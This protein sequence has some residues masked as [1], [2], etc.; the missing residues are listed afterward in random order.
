MQSSGRQWNAMGCNAKQRKAKQKQC[1][2]NAK[3]MQK[4]CDAKGNAQQ[5]KAM[6]WI[7]NATQCQA[8]QHNTIEHNKHNTTQQI[9]G[10]KCYLS[11][12]SAAQGSTQLKAAQGSARQCKK[13]K[14]GHQGRASFVPL[15]PSRWRHLSS[16]RLCSVGSPASP[17]HSS[18][19]SRSSTLSDSS[20][21]CRRRHHHHITIIITIT[22]IIPKIIII[23]QNHHHHH[24][25]SKSPSSSSSSQSPSFIIF[26]RITSTY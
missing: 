6:H 2:S 17:C 18:V 23:S 13:A 16:C 11:I 5:C 25:K 8:T 4:Q 14:A 22:I 24:H 12:S 3:A 19:P 15:S 7:I 9:I 10:K 20:S 1:K 21:S 26:S